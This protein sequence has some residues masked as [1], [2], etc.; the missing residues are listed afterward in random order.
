MQIFKF[1]RLSHI[2]FTDA[3]LTIYKRTFNLSMYRLLFRLYPDTCID[4]YIRY[5]NYDSRWL[6]TRIYRKYVF[7]CYSIGYLF[8]RITKN[9]D[10]LLQ[11]KKQ[12]RYTK[13]IGL[14]MCIYP[15]AIFHKFRSQKD[16]CV[17]VCIL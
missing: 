13:E 10:S 7:R 4:L 2:I 9:R 8:C 16:A 1:L 15:S 3:Y 11:Y 12:N 6:Y 17:C 14:I 5:G